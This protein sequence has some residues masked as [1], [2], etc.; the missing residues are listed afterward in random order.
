MGNF[1]SIVSAALVLGSVSGNL[2]GP[3]T[4]Q[5]L[6]DKSFAVIVEAVMPSVVGITSKGMMDPS[7]DDASRRELN[8]PFMVDLFGSGVVAD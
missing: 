8:A 1:L 5:S 4:A 7:D 6:P 3:A 2:C